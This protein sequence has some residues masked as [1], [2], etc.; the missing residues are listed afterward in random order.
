MVKGQSR[1]EQAKTNRPT[2][3]GTSRDD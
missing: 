2:N 1:T 3:Y